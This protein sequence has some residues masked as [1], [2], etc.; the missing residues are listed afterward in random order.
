[1]EIVDGQVHLNLLGSVEAGLA[2]MDAAGVEVMLLSAWHGPQGS[3]VSNDEVAAAV[4]R[5]MAS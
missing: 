1:M 3:L 4:Q 5:S 2:A